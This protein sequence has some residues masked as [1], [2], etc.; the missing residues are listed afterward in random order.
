[1]E[2]LTKNQQY[3]RSRYEYLDD[4]I[5]LIALEAE[6]VL[7]NYYNVCHYNNHHNYWE[8]DEDITFSQLAELSLFYGINRH[9][10]ELLEKVG[11]NTKKVNELFIYDESFNDYVDEKVKYEINSFTAFDYFN[12]YYV[13]YDYNNNLDIELMLY[14]LLEE[15][16]KIFDVYQSTCYQETK[17]G[18]YDYKLL[19]QY[20]HNV[21]DNLDDYYETTHAIKVLKKGISLRN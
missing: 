10:P 20:R 13:D 15:D 1:M 11:F 3:L 5:F 4:D 18:N 2:Q 21:E 17:Q 14:Y 9:H 19:E 12:Q 7:T 6:A 16:S 8:L